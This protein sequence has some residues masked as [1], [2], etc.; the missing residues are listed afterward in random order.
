MLAEESILYLG[1]YAETNIITWVQTFVFC[2]YAG[3]PW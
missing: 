3:K 1:L 2:V